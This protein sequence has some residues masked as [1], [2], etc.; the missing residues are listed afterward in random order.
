MKGN[1]FSVILLP[2]NKCNVNCDYCFEDKTRDNMTMERLSVLIDRVFDHM[3]RSHVGALTIYWQ[4]GEIMTMPPRWFEQ[5]YEVIQRAAQARNKQVQHSLQSNMIGYN[6]GWN[7]IIAEMFGNSVGTSM[8]YPNLHRKMFH[9]GA[10]QY[11]RLCYR[12][13]HAARA[14]GRYLSGIAGVNQA[15]PACGAEND[16]AYLLAYI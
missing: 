11:T 6:K 4:G 5:A 10:G 2:T 13:L 3:E 16:F 14:A 1:H 9:G 8:D 15:T 12:N 7:K